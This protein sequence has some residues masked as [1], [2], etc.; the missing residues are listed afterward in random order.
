MLIERFGDFELDE[1]AAT[2]R[3]R[4]R[5]VVLQP[6]VFSLLVFLV[7]CRDRVVGKEELLEAV[8]PRMVVTDSS[9]QRAI[10]LARGALREGG[11]DGAIRTYPR[12][13]Y[14]F[15]MEP[16]GAPGAA[17]IASDHA[18]PTMLEGAR[19]AYRQS[20]W[21]D[22]VSSFQMADRLE[23][24]AAEDLERWALAAQCSGA[25]HE[26]IAPLERAASA[27]SASQDVDAAARALILLARIQLESLETAVAKGCLSRATSLLAGRPECTQHGHLAWMNARFAVFEGDMVAATEHARRAIEI[28]SSLGDNDIATM[29]LLYTGVALQA[30]GQTQRGIELQDEAAAAVVT[31]DVSPLV[32][33]IVYCG[34]IAACC[35][36][37]DWPRAGQWSASFGRWCERSNLSTFAGSCLLHRAEVFVSRG[38]L[39]RA[40]AELLRGDAILRTSAPWA[41]G[42]AYR[43]LGDV[44][45]ARGEFGPAED[46]YRIA[47]QHGWDP[48]PGYGMLLHFKGQ[49]AAALRGLKRALEATH[50]VAGERRGQY[51]AATAV[52]AALSGDI[53]VA[54]STLGLLD[55]SPDLWSVGSVAAQVGRARGEVA[56]A[57]GAAGEAVQHFRGATRV[58][59]QMGLPVDAAVVGTRLATALAAT[60]D[61]EGAELELQ[62]AAAALEKSEATFYLGLCADVRRRLGAEQRGKS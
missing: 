3:F 13:G 48:Y 31:G 39:S 44:R 57:A 1:G 42:E 36:A 41:V 20:R 7:R 46:A 6:R 4:G 49:S 50:W 15:C 59:Q 43:L 16:S 9:L 38:E 18:L 28:G 33:G 62:R 5:E 60:G 25:L 32:G 30:T 47:H 22:A 45:L 12:R 61:V 29:G 8:W 52:I 34:L 23:P 10:S 54:A 11:L 53:D 40:Q 37:G 21:V 26:A 55:A 56:L 14:R 58:L 2:L 17:P 24:L 51:L 35:N 19:E 27:Y